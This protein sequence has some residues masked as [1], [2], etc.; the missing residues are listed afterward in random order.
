MLLLG[1]RRLLRGAGVELPTE[2]ALAAGWL[3]G[4]RRVDVGHLVK[5]LES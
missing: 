4:R 3:D 1:L 2:G 5:M